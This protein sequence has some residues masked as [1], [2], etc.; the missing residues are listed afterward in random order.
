MRLRA[1]RLGARALRAIPRILRASAPYLIPAILLDALYVSG[2]LDATGGQLVPA[3]DDAFIHFEYGRALAEGRPLVY[4][5]GD[6][7]TTGATSLF[8][9]A[10]LAI[11]ALLGLRG[12]AMGCGRMVRDLGRDPRV[13]GPH[14][15][16]HRASF[17]VRGRGVHGARLALSRGAAHDA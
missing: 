6:A 4:V 16:P 9:M 17:A 7:P 13:A 12:L 11:G 2:I 14:R 15:E 3:L 10:L 5:E 1:A 8:Y